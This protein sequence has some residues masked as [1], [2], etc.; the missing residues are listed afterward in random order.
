VDVAIAELPDHMLSLDLARQ[1]GR[2][3]GTDEL[4]R[5]FLEGENLFGRLILAVIPTLQEA[6]A[7]ELVGFLVVF[8]CMILMR[9]GY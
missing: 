6:G 2:R 9:F 7:R 5:V 1:M 4:A 3:V 8:T